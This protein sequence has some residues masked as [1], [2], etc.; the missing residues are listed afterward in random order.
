MEVKKTIVSWRNLNNL[1]NKIVKQLKDKFPN[2]TD[3]NII[4][5]SRGGLVPSV[6][7][8][9]ILNIRK[10]YSLGLKSYN[11]TNKE[12]VEIYQI[13]D[14]S[15]MEKILLID[16][17]SDTGESFNLSKEMMLNKE[18]VTVSLYVKKGTKFMPDV[19]GKSVL[20]DVWVVFPWE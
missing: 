18:V 17:I 11:E 16:D 12:K 15:N 20:N 5:L 7:I 13:P 10:V 14:I 3:Y 9:N 6:V 2:I 19:Y 1:C 8:S 4:G